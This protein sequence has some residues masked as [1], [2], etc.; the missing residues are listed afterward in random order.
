MGEIFSVIW[1]KKVQKQ[2]VNI[3]SPIAKK[4][5]AWV[6]A[7]RIAGLRSV[8]SRP[9]FHDE[10]LRGDRQGQRSIRLNQAWRAIYVEHH[11]GALELIEVI[12]V[13]HHEY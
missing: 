6:T 10:S 3:P 4:F 12:E 13:T 2:L 7:V 8:R 5:F 11:D 1:S 9:G